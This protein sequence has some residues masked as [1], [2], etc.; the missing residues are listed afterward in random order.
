LEEIP[1]RLIENLGTPTR[2]TGYGGNASLSR[3]GSGYGY[4]QNHR[5]GLAAGVGDDF[6]G[7]H[8]SYEDEDQS[9]SGV[10]SS[11]AMPGRPPA[12]KYAGLKATPYPKA[13]VAVWPPKKTD[14]A[15]AAKT[16]AKEPDS[17]D[18]IAKFFGGRAGGTGGYS[19]PKL[20]IPVMAGEAGLQKGMRVRHGKYGDGTVILR[21]GDGEDAKLT[22]HFAKFGV[23]KLIEKFAQLKK[24]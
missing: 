24:V 18:N 15:S 23:K 13:G 20:V 22:V 3:Y 4:G 5:T 11:S 10:R 8:Y 2:T 9:S 19:R 6:N 7:G 16:S 14:A 17:I 21:E 12:G 1:G